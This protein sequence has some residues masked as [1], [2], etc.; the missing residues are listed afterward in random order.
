M[1]RILLSDDDFEPD[2]AEFDIQNQ[3]VPV[4]LDHGYDDPFYRAEQEGDTSEREF[5]ERLDILLEADY[6]EEDEILS[7]DDLTAL[8]EEMERE[9][10]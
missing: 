10:L 4:M 9:G 6:Q 8:M 1:D 3:G 7:D 2:D 5:Q